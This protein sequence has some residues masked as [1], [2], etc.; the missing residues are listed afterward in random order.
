LRSGVAY[1][2][3]PVSHAAV[4]SATPGAP[5]RWRGDLLSFLHEQL[6]YP[7]RQ[8]Q[9]AGLRLALYRDAAC[10]LPFCLVDGR[11]AGEGADG[12]DDLVATARREEF[13][14]IAIDTERA[15]Q[16]GPPGGGYRSV[17]TLP[18]W[19]PA[20]DRKALVPR[21]VTLLPFR[22]EEALRRAFAGCHN[23]IYKQLARDPAATFDLLTL[24]IAAKILDEQPDSGEY[25]FSR[26]RDENSDTRVTRFTSLLVR[27]QQ[28]I[29]LRGDDVL[30]LPRPGLPSAL[31]EGIAKSFQDYSLNLTAHSIAGAD[32]LGTAFESIVGATFRGE[33]GAYFT[34]R[35]ISDFIVRLLEIRAGRVFDPAC[36]TGGLL[37]AA[38]RHAVSQAGEVEC[39]GNDINPRMV[40]AAR[41]NFLLHELDYHAI[42]QGD[43]LE[44]DRMFLSWFEKEPPPRHGCWWKVY[45][46]GRFDTVVANPP[47]AGHEQDRAN[48]AR[49]E[50]AERSDG[51]L[52]ALNR[53]I[54]F[55]EAIV[56]SLKIGGTAGI[57]LPTS[58]LNAEEESFVRFRELLLDHVELMAIIGLPE[59]AFVHTD[60][61][62]HGALLFFRRVRKPRSD[63]DVFVGW[64][65]KLGYDR[66]GRDI[67]DNDLP[68]ILAAYRQTEWPP[69]NSV[70]I[71]K[72]LAWRRFDPAWIKVVDTLPENDG[73]QAGDYVPLTEIVRVRDARISR[74]SLDPDGTYVY[75]EV[76]DTDIA[77]GDIVRVH[78]G[79]GWELQR[80]S[81]IKNRVQAGDVLLPNHRDSLIAK[82]A[83]T[84]R[85]AVI[86]DDTHDGVLTTDRFI[87]LQPLVD[88]FLAIAVLN[89]AGVR[90]QIVAQSRGAASLDI[91]ER[92]LRSVL[93][94]RSVV[95]GQIATDIV[96]LSTDV[97]ELRQTLATKAGELSVLTEDGFGSRLDFRP[98]AFRSL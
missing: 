60:C 28:W 75:F 87:V 40:H 68:S 53:T 98:D 50:T 71:R 61:G 22:T 65:E 46:D 38:H 93:V 47:F 76:S 13:E 91:R 19:M 81:R 25:E 8:V 92:T 37:V 59:R 96:R 57:V 79:R 67:P 41:V 9:D 18:T 66:L 94:P 23:L 80:K 62:V 72:L 82:G 29:E 27:A 14:F 10:R 16:L 7:L 4:E 6:L 73:S 24:V 39:F 30:V 21:S 45:T 12:W 42:S 3:V 70:S 51:S 44:L 26:V 1:T 34:P 85:S 89:S 77:S 83:P 48:L 54:P 69:E 20:Y 17:P 2:L 97:R 49:I 33:L 95:E 74:R 52:R 84:G 58:V 5:A 36:G 78:D 88:P 32:V 86:V 55:I 35:R 63:Y 43:G 11:V 31:V 15:F 64:V 90:R 56:A